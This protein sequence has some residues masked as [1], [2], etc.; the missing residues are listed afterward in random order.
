MVRII[1]PIAH[2]IEK[3]VMALAKPLPEKQSVA[4][5]REITANPEIPSPCKNP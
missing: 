5:A 3:Y 4:T 1:G 2:A